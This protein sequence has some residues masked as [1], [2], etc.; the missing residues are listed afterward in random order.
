[1]KRML[2]GIALFATGFFAIISI[3]MMAVQHPHIY[4][5]IG[6]LRGFLL[7]NQLTTLYAIAWVLTIVGLI[8]CVY[9]VLK[10]S[11]KKK[12]KVVHLLSGTGTSLDKLDEFLENGWEV[13][14][15]QS[16]EVGCFVWIKQS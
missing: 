16:A 5:D 10:P 6:G 3:R 12:T 7:A 15:I 11:A 13:V 1:M 9:E 2:F 4:N 14:Q 8:L